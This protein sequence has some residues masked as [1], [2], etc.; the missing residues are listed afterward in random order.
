MFE[1]VGR[2][3]VEPRGELGAA[4][5]AEL[6]GVELDPEAVGLRGL[7]QPLDLVREEADPFAKAVD[8]VA[9]PALAT[10]GI[11]SSIASLTNAARSFP[12]GSAWSASKVPTIAHRLAVAERL[13]GVEQP[14]FRA[15]V[16]AV[17]GL[18]LDR[19]AAAGHQR[20]EAAAGAVDQ[21]GRRGRLGLGDRRGDP[22][23]G[24]GDFLIGRAGAAH[25][26]LVGAGA[27]EHEM[28]VAIDQARRDPGAA[29]RNDLL[30][31]EAGELGALADA[32]D[33][34]VLDPD[35]AI[36][37]GPERIAA[38]RKHGRDMAVDEQAVPHVRFP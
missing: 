16:H 35:R 38:H 24:L 12:G 9:R 30:R 4:A 2:Q 33:L 32:D 18:D 37:D 1:M 19:R 10:A 36:G 14:H 3:C 11:I 26:M 25:R 34:A 17:A 7:E 15:R 13:G 21:L 5:V 6:L 22:A 31:A 27:A 23:A 28:G 20:V 8:A 29:E